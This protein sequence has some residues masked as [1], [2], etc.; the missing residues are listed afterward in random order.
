MPVEAALPVARSFAHF[1][2]LANIAEQ[3]HR[4]SAAARAGARAGRPAAAGVDRRGAAAAARRR[5]DRRMRCIDAIVR[6]RIE[7]VMTAHPTE[8]MR[9]TL[10][11]KYNRIAEALGGLDRPDLTPSEREALLETMRREIA[12]AWHTED[13]RRERPSPLDEVRSG[14]AV[15]EETIWNAVPEFCRSLDRRCA[16]S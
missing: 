1:L 13:V 2:N 14:M 12:G 8:I 11:H 10:Q 3:H 6:L 7:L 5:P 16:G 9:R 4:D 15:F